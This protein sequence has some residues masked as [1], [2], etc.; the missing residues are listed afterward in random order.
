MGKLDVSQLRYLT[1]EDF[2]AL[3]AVEMCMKNHETVP[4]DLLA[5]VANFKY[6]GTYKVVKDLSRHRLL[7]YERSNSSAHV[8]YRLTNKG[9][10]YL[11]LRVLTKRGSIDA[12]GNQ[13]GVGK[14]SDIYTVA[15]EDRNEY[16]L[17]VHRL[18]RTSFRAIKNK[19]DYH[20]KRNI[21]NWLY[22]SRISATK[23]FAFMCCLHENDFPVPKPVDCNRHCVVMELINGYPLHQVSKDDFADVSEITEVYNE[24]MNLIL[25]LACNG[26]IHGDFNEFNLMINDANEITLIDF[27]QMMSI[28]HSNAKFYFDRDVAGV[29]D[30]FERTLKFVSTEPVPD[31]DKDVERTGFLDKNLSATG[32]RNYVKNEKTKHDKHEDID[33]FGEDPADELCSKLEDECNVE[34]ES[35]GS[36]SDEAPSLTPPNSASEEEED[37][38]RKEKMR[39]KRQINKQVGKQQKEARR[40]RLK[41][42]EASMHNKQKRLLRGDIS[43]SVKYGF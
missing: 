16:A 6:G 12:F 20:L 8:G 31:F 4:V 9:Y 34:D 40:R 15:D 39:M 35:D 13:I 41:K 21:P 18:G 25:R 2:R 7:A 10:D 33:M 1:Q 24:L 37:T 27:P 3:T 14:E 32:W 42:G 30:F 17:K 43:G 19:R 36:Q 38:E 28:S 29:R 23:E 22:L 26:L 5:S 11:A